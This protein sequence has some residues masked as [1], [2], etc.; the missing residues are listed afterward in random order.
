[1][2]RILR[3]SEVTTN[4]PCGFSQALIT[5]LIANQWRLDGFSRWLQ[6]LR[7]QYRARRDAMLDSFAE[8]F[9]LRREDGVGLVASSHGYVGYPKRRHGKSEKT[10]RDVALCSFVPPTSGMFGASPRRCLADRA[11]WLR[12]HFENHPDYAR[13]AARQ[14]GQAEEILLDRVFKRCAER[15]VLI[16]PGIFFVP[17][18]AGSVKPQHVGYARLSYSSA[19]RDELSQAIGTLRDVL[20]SEFRL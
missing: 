12:M 5:E 16:V 15:L 3:A 10:P 20:M 9:D 14:D 17:T 6:G 11:V 7:A 1:M 8:A 4:A 18:H 19:T 13:L 2:Q